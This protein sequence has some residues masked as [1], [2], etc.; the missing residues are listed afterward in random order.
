[1][2]NGETPEVS[3]PGLDT[4]TEAVPTKAM[5]AA[6]ISAVNCPEVRNVVGREFEFQFTTEPATKL[7]PFT[8]RVNAEPPAVALPGFSTLIAGVGGALMENG[9]TPEV[10]PPGLDTVTG[11]YSRS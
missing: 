6:E 2:V 9:E 7:E 1:M 11:G 3:P 8:V 4:V 10:T 5:S